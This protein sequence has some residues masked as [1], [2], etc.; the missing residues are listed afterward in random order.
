MWLI[1]CHTIWL[2]HWLPIS[3]NFVLCPFSPDEGRIKNNIFL[4]PVSDHFDLSILQV[5]AG[6]VPITLQMRNNL[7]LVHFMSSK[8]I[9]CVL[10]C[11]LTLR[12]TERLSSS[13]D[14]LKIE[15]ILFCTL[16]LSSLNTSIYTGF[17]SCCDLL[18]A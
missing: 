3:L 5:F 1:G 12:L 7:Y 14:M 2:F 4:A 17:L 18:R 13:L 9:L 6:T 10:N 15:W 11:M 16:P 8:H